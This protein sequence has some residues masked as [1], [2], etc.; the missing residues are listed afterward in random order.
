MKNNQ[1]LYWKKNIRLILRCLVIWFA[2]SFGCGILFVDQLNRFSIGGYKLG[3]WFAQ[4]GSIYVFLILIY[5]Y[6]RS[7]SKLDKEFD[8]HEDYKLPRM[9]KVED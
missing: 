6:T 7:M 5:Y 8:V 4:Q 1:Q 2:V 3:F 9:S